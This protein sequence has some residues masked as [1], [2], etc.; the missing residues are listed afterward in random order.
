MAWVNATHLH[1]S[2]AGQALQDIAAH[3]NWHAGFEWLRSLPCEMNACCV[4]VLN[5]SSTLRPQEHYDL[6]TDIPCHYTIVG[7]SSG[8]A[9]GL[10]RLIRGSQ[11]WRLHKLVSLPMH[12]LSASVGDELWRLRGHQI[13]SGLNPAQFRSWAE[14]RSYALDLAVFG[15]NQLELAHVSAGALPVDTITNF[16]ATVSSVAGMNVSLWWQCAAASAHMAELPSLFHAMPRLDAVFFPGGDGGSL[17]FSAIALS[18]DAAASSHPEAT[19]WCVAPISHLELRCREQGT[20][21][22]LIS[23][24]SPPH[25]T[26]WPWQGKSTRPDLVRLRLHG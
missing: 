22:G 9:A 12:N 20:Q 18:K 13:S 15:T 5:H 4:S 3:A 23:P 16:S 2:G 7:G 11:V 8:V 25:H 6:R 17:N 26:L 24:S 1:L 14:L 19:F 21:H 10:R